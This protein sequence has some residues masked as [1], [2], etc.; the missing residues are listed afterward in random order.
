[1]H[2]SHLK[3][4]YYVNRIDCCIVLCVKFLLKKLNVM[5]IKARKMICNTKFDECFNV[6]YID[7]MVAQ[8]NIYLFYTVYC[9]GAISNQ[10][11]LPFAFQ[12]HLYSVLQ[13]IY[14][15]VWI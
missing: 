7:Y 13:L 5:N 12:A 11:I 15:S 8:Q 2:A 9:L 10:F 14:L 4:S 6:F 3:M 1:M